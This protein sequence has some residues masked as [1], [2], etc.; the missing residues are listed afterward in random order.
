MCECSVLRLWLALD[1]PYAGFA[2]FS[3]AAFAECPR[4]WRV[5]ENSPSLCPTMF[6]VTYTGMNLRPLCTA[7]V[8]P[9]NSGKIVERRD[10]V[11]TTF[12]SFLSF[13]AVIFFL[14]MSST[15][16]PFANAMPL[17]YRSLTPFHPGSPG[18]LLGRLF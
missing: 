15:H 18:P 13:M 2:V 17:G 6:S 16:R 9:M 14:H 11:R 12:F 8:C 4:N 7:S 5:G 1:I 3:A 10:H